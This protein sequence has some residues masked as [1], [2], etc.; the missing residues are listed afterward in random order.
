MNISAA[1][2]N[3]LKAAV[4]A[5]LKAMWRP[6]R[7]TCAEYAD[8][9]FYMSSESSY[10]EGKW[11]SLPFQIGILNA[12]GNDLITTLN[13]M[14]SARVGY[15][16]ML[17]AN[18]AYKIEHKKRNVL[19][20]QPRDK[21]A[22]SFMKKHVEPAIRDIPVWGALA[23]W[24]GKKHRDSTLEDKVFSNGK[25]LMVRG[26]AAAANYR[27]ISTDDVIYDELAGFDESIERE[28]NATGLGDTRLE[29]SVF[30]KS[31]RGSTPK[32][33][34]SC[35]MEKA[36]SESPYHFH[37]YL[38]CPHCGELQRLKWGGKDEPFGIKWQG[39][40]PK[41]AYYLCEHCACVIE[42]KCLTAMQE[43]P[44]A[45]WICE[46]TGIWTRDFL[47]F[48]D[49]EGN[50]IATP[51]NVAIYIWS[52]YNPLS[53]WRKLVTDFYKA[54]GDKE[55]LQTFVNTKLGQPWDDDT[56]EKLE[57]E[58]L[59]RRR[60]M[61][62]AGKVPSRV[63]YLTAGVDTQD[64]RYEGRV[65]GWAAGQE[66]FLVDRFILNGKPDS[67]Q[68]LDA[69]A[70]RLNRTY[71]RADGIVMPIGLVAWDSGGHYTDVVYSMSKKLG[72]MRV[73]PVKGANVY[74]KPIANFPRKRNSK[75]V[76]L[77]EVGTDNAKE[78]IMSRLR[79]LPDI[80]E[81]KPG[82]IHLPLNEAVCDDAELQ[83][84]T[85]ERKIPVR[86][87]GRIVYRW[88]AGKKRNEALDCFVYA[89]AALY[90]ALERFGIDLDKLTAKA[91]QTA[92]VEAEAEMRPATQ[93]KPTTSKSSGWL[94]TS[95]SGWL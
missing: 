38:P 79:L 48:F 36:C 10:S 16:K 8:E 22:A 13:V 76:Y 69:V 31:I 75:G 85:A 26:G 58:D 53:S 89:L 59:A 78:L 86:R 6:P 30:P 72:L 46:K 9:H 12:M 47:A 28:G 83:Q 71:T 39:D 5:G 52:A 2:V 33:L 93:P 74:G 91:A 29:L 34:G 14:K 32:I 95:G 65:W 40:D 23:P 41:T 57:W 43:S 80:T 17:M 24:L 88:D 67:Q 84:L 92:E 66:A 15:T 45:K 73:I 55:K 60:E 70:E 64:D 94:K 87:D 49:S 1:Q 21:Q 90:I 4:A 77:T 81:A 19:M 18:A 68:L 37:F 63:V 51:D 44:A 56:G 54:K 27:E 82:A 3:N 61:Y 42:N 11:K 50:E 20:Y 7:M 35:Q 25:T 62:P